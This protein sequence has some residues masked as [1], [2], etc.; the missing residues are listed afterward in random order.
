MERADELISDSLAKELVKKS[1][2]SVI[3]GGYQKGIIN[4][5]TLSESFTD[6]ERVDINIL[7]SKGLLSDNTAYLKV[8]ARGSIDKP[9]SVYAN[10][11]SLS[12]VKMIALTGGEAVKVVTVKKNTRDFTD[13]T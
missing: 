5:D 6:G 13:N 10:D 7:K 12:A 4:V 11:F 2:E 1:R 3:T 9:L 8:L